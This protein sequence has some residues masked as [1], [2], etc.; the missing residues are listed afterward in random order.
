[1]IRQLQRASMAV[2]L[3]GSG[4]LAPDSGS[5]LV[6]TPSPLTQRDWRTTSSKPPVTADAVPGE[7]QQTS[8]LSAALPPKALADANLS[9]NLDDLVR[10]A[11]ER[12]PRIARAAI[13]IDA[14]QGRYIQAGLYPN[15]DLA[16]IWDDIGD[17]TA[18]GGVMYAPQIGQTFITGRKLSLAQS[19]VSKE[20]DQASLGV[21]TERYAVVGS[22]RANFYEVLALQERL[23][24]LQELVTVAEQSV[25]QGKTLVAGQRLARL[26]LI[27]LEVALEQ[28]RA[29]AAAVERE[30][31]AAYQK[32]A[33]TIGDARLPLRK[34]AGVFDA[35]PEYD[36]DAV[37]DA[38][39]TYH[40]EA[41]S[42]HVGVERAQAAIRSAEAQPI[43]NVTISGGFIRQFENQSYDGA[44][45][46]SAPIPVWN[47]NQGNIREARANLS[48]AMQTV[49][50]VENTLADRVAIA[51]RTYA[52]GRHRAEQYRVEIIPRAEETL[53]LSLEAFKGGQFEYLRVLQAQRAVA[54]AKLE[55]NRS[56]GEAWKAAGEL[57]GL[58][59]E[60]AWPR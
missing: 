41:R 26:D 58:L 12:N 47:R 13:A 36:L 29:E 46:L 9:T 44:F 14:A 32:L 19:V 39:L 3:A 59:L 34:L 17:R 49:L 43:P 4:C 37:R 20:I 18:A 54:E 30:L 22:V 56:L 53:R 5:A 48:M 38:V 57:S 16:F 52:A 2:L 11:V 7:I 51:F 42:A 1:M 6:P 25:E 33:A 15:P 10:I 23:A 40:P 35:P 24:I 27:Q 60:E 21:L 28:F 55:R 45:G 50:H 31:P 8:F